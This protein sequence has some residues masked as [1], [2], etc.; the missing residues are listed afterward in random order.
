MKEVIGL[1]LT[2]VFILIALLH[3]NW[4][5]G[6]KWG[7]NGTLPIDRDRISNVRNPGPLAF[8]IVILG[9]LC[10][11]GLCGIKAGLVNIPIPDIID[12]YGLTMIATIFLLRV[13]GEFKYIGLF[14]KIKSTEFARKDTKYYIPLCLM[15]AIFAILLQLN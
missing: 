14:K 13:I 11:A 15:I 10:M 8:V 2:L 12:R 3:I 6:G 7:L 1:L 4:G 5:L 9:L